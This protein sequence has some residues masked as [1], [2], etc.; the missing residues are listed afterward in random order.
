MQPEARSGRSYPPHQERVEVVR[1]SR[2]Y[3]Q[4]LT[5]TGAVSSG[6]DRGAGGVASCVW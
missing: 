6:G 3:D 4:Y 5:A 2:A 1:G